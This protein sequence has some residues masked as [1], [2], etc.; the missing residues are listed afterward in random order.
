MH[1]SGAFRSG[2][3][4]PMRRTLLLVSS[5]ALAAGALTSVSFLAAAPA[6]AVTNL[7][8]QANVV[9]TCVAPGVG[10]S[11]YTGTQPIS[12]AVAA[13]TSGGTIYI[14]PGT[15]A[16]NVTVTVPMTIEGSGQGSTIIVPEFSNPTGY[17]DVTANEFDST[18]FLVQ[19]DNVAIQ[20]LTINGSN[21]SATTSPSP[22]TSGAPCD[23]TW[24]AYGE[25]GG[26]GGVTINA[27]AAIDTGIPASAVTGM[28]VQDVTIKNVYS[29]GIADRSYGG[30]FSFS[31]D[32]ITNIGGEGQGIFTYESNG[33]MA[34]DSVSWAGVGIQSNWGA[35]TVTGNTVENSNWGIFLGNIGE[36]AGYADGG[37]SAVSGNAVSSCWGQ[38]FFAGASTGDSELGITFFAPFA[39]TAETASNNT[40]TGCSTG[41]AE[42]SSNNDEPLTYTTPV[43]TF[44]GNTVNGQGASNGIGALVST[45]KLG[46]NNGPVDA[47]FTGNSIT[48]FPTA[49]YTDETNLDNWAGQDD[50]SLP[51]G[52]TVSASDN[53]FAGTWFNDATGPISATDNWWGTPAGPS[54][55]IG[56]PDGETSSAFIS[57]AAPTWRTTPNELPT[58]PREVSATRG[59]GSVAVS[60]LAPTYKGSTDPA[61]TITSYHV[62]ASPGGGTCS[63]ATLGCTVTG[64]TNGTSYSFTL[65]ATTTIGT[66][67][68]SSP[69]VSATPATTPGAPVAVLA[70]PS[71]SSAAV[72]WTGPLSNGGSGI[73]RYTATAAPGGQSCQTAGTSCRVNGLTPGTSYT[74]TVTATNGVGTGPGLASN[75][76]VASALATISPFAYDSS[77]LTSTTKSEIRSLATQIVNDGATSVVLAG[78]TNPGESRSGTSSSRLGLSRAVAVASY[79]VQVLRS[80][81]STGV[82][83]SERYGGNVRISQTQPSVNR[84]VVATL[85]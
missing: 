12:A 75:T 3:R 15:W 16:D 38:S 76:V 52:L 50:P 32:T 11:Q 71:F 60:W 82:V 65:T 74:F 61:V 45:D 37:S 48:N 51:G 40:V 66:G 41:L 80:D 64:L 27:G 43:V 53:D 22:W 70:K 36:P 7:P 25:D 44:S 20:N 85:T 17:G 79:L 78:Y 59:N 9:G 83:L 54:V 8:A 23:A 21:P 10:G 58:A 81:G 30:T 56:S 33:T 73:V 72:S 14:C 31:D 35:I 49:L 4:R 5:T 68:A 28:T 1:G 13:T 62:T 26:C 77:R 24:A 19:A 42:F 6:G 2:G 18:V 84:R 47:H 46:Y 57:R 55:T 69:A 34:N 29:V 63:T 39:P 67:P